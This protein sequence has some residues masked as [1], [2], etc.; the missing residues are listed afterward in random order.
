MKNVVFIPNIN[1]GDGRSNPFKYSIAS[2]EKWCDKNDCDL[3]ILD[4]PICDVEQ[5][6]I[7]SQR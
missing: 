3:V 6:K 2:W 7:T 4:K 5:M 1:L